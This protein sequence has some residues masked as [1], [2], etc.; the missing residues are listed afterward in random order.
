MAGIGSSS[1]M[2]S[3]TPQQ[4]P[5]LRLMNDP[6]MHARFRAGSAPQAYQIAAQM[7]APG[8]PG[9]AYGP[10]NEFMFSEPAN[11]V[12][13]WGNQA[14]PGMSDAEFSQGLQGIN[15]SGARRKAEMAHQMGGGSG[16]DPST[17]Y[18]ASQGLQAGQDQAVGG[19]HAQRA[20]L[21]RQSMLDATRALSPYMKEFAGQQQDYANN[22]AGLA[23]NIMNDSQFNIGTPRP[24]RAS[25]GM[26]L[27]GGW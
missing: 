6:F 9:G 23:G 21:N 15:Q 22:I 8:A 10:S 11:A 20:Q 14:N 24:P 19:L 16:I 5:S 12:N 1:G 17:Y 3:M 18:R 2:G 13:K 27:G 4:D 7:T 25:Y 26:P